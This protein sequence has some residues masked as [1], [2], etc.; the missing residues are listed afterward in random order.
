MVNFRLHAFARAGKDPVR[1]QIL[2]ARANGHC[3]F[4]KSC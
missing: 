4:P 2:R 1:V 3:F